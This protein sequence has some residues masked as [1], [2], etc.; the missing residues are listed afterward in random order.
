VYGSSPGS[1]R[2]DIGR[3]HT[4]ADRQRPARDR[5]EG[6]EQNQPSRYASS[7]LLPT[8]NP[9]GL[10]S[11]VRDSGPSHP[12]DS[13]RR[14]FMDAYTL[15]AQMNGRSTST[16]SSRY[17]SPDDDDIVYLG[18]TGNARSAG[19][20][21]NIASRP[22]LLNASLSTGSS[23]VSDR[24]PPPGRAGES[25]LGQSSSGASRGGL[26]SSRFTQGMFVFVFVFVL[27]YALS[28]QSLAVTCYVTPVMLHFFIFAT[29]C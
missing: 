21:H 7:R 14:H 29:E 9:S 19:N 26:S 2:S 15:S 10:A 28:K 17:I 13:L 27:L 5:N 4:N 22:E 18:N 3:R 11:S 12:A 20:A 24:F 8:P 23:A 1:G 6:D 16:R 25:G